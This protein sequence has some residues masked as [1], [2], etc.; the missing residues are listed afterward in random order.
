[1]NDLYL[2]ATATTPKVNF[3]AQK[4]FLEIEGESYPENA[5]RFFEPLLKWIDDYLQENSQKGMEVHLKFNYFN[6]SS[7]KCILD[8]MELMER[9]A[10]EGTK[11]RVI[12]H[13]LEQDEDILQSGEEFAEDVALDFTFV[14]Y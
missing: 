1:M 13:Y 3:D 2:E 14:S 6:T 10:Q 7:S 8:M 12:W 5:Y 4:G 11:I 9:H